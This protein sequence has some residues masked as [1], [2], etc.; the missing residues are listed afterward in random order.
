MKYTHE[1]NIR[2]TDVETKPLTEF[3]TKSWKKVH[4][5]SYFR[6]FGALPL[7]KQQ[8][9][10]TSK[11]RLRVFCHPERYPRCSFSS[12]T[13]N[14][15]YHFHGGGSWKRWRVTFHTAR[16]KT[17][18]GPGASQNWKACSESEGHRKGASTQGKCLNSINLGNQFGDF[19]GWLFWQQ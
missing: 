2:Q 12:G 17:T 11:L 13:C 15:L 16:F 4:A 7:P 3:T 9:I 18:Y 19:E 5:G 10:P 14:S 6:A 1:L 8:D